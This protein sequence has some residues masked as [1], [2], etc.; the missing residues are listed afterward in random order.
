MSIYQIIKGI[1]KLDRINI[2]KCSKQQPANVK[3]KAENVKLVMHGLEC[4]TDA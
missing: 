2:K 1:K 3:L 4:F